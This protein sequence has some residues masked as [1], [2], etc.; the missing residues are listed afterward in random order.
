MT[1]P[2]RTEQRLTELEIKVSYSDDLLDTLNTIVAQQQQTIDQLRREVQLLRQ[3]SA[4][5]G[6]PA[7]R[8]L[9]DD[10]PPHY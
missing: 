4:D 10:L 9:A 3:Q 8:S 1:S 6:T 5:N 2:D 7:F